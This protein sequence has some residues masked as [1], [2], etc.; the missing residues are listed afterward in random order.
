MAEARRGPRV[1]VT[2]LTSAPYEVNVHV[3]REGA[4]ALVVDASSGADWPTFGPR[5]AEA[6]RGAERARNYLTHWHVDHVGGVARMG[7]LAGGAEALIHEDEAAAVEKGDATLTL[8]AFMGQ[9]QEPYPVTRLREGSVVELGSRRLEVLLV[10]GHSPAHTALWDPEGRAL[11]SGDVVFE[12]GS[13][14]RVDFPGCDPDAL[15]RSLERLA[16]LDPVAFYPGHMRP[17]ERG[18]REAILES[19]D[20]ARLTLG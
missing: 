7:A 17:V 14:G 11:F 5:V 4:D 15:V 10:P 2:T 6:L 18:A 3:L 13:F 20:N 1:Q 19:L 16:A 8:G 12:G 9:D